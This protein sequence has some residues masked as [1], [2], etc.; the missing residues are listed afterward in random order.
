MHAVLGRL[1]RA[2]YVIGIDANYLWL[3]LQWAPEWLGDFLMEFL[4]E[5]APIPNACQK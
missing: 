2:R 5:D 4:A 1:P 3:P